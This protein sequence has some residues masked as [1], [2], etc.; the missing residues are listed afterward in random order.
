MGTVNSK[1]ENTESL[2]TLL[3]DIASEYILTTPFNDL[4]E[5]FDDAH[6]NKLIVTTSKVLSNKFNIREIGH[7][8]KRLTN[9][10]T[11][12]HH[13]NKV[14]FVFK[15]TLNNIDSNENKSKLCRRIAAFYMR[16]FMLYD[17]ILKTINPVFIYKDEHTGIQTITSFL[18]KHTMSNTNKQNAKLFSYSICMKRLHRFYIDFHNTIQDNKNRTFSIGIK[19]DKSVKTLDDE[20]GIPELKELYYDLFDENIN[21]YSK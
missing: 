1:K 5:A 14:G 19:C 2:F 21:M 13:E 20:P 10:N 6:C 8:N 3:D 11:D 7:L 15:N 17:A 12:R 4:T 9:G 16:I 18:K